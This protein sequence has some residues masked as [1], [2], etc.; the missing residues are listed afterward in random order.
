MRRR[1]SERIRCLNRRRHCDCESSIAPCG[2]RCVGGRTAEKLVAKLQSGRGVCFGCRGSAERREILICKSG[3][4]I[5]AVRQEMLE[6]MAEAVR[7]GK[8][9]IPIR[10]NCHSVKRPRLKKGSRKR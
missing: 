8:L 10:Q 5:L 3:A 7:D 4:R 1:R 6:F 2:R 9:V